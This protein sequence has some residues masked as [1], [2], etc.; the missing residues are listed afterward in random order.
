MEW[1]IFAFGCAVL[2]ALSAILQKKTLLKEHAAEFSSTFSVI[3]VLVSLVLIPWVEFNITW[4][5]LSIIFA[6]AFFAAIGF[7]LTVKALRHMDISVVS[8]M[9]NLSPALLAIIAFFVLGERLTLMQITGIVV[10]IIGSYILEIDHKKHSLL[11]PFRELWKS[12]YLHLLLISLV[13]YAFSAVTGKYALSFVKPITLVFFSQIFVAILFFLLLDFEYN[14]IEGI[15]HGLKNF[16]WLILVAA[17]LT[18]SYRVLQSQAM[19][20]ALVSLVI[21]IKRLSTLFSTIIGGELFKEHGLK[22]KCIACI[23]MIAGATLI[24]LG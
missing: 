11:S 24:V 2:A 20:M 8:P 3:V 13:S 23:I 17:V 10:L 12:K 1:F 6:S 14:G 9:R 16:G 15:K 4:F 5:M 19:S 22:E 18:V 21:P 7:L